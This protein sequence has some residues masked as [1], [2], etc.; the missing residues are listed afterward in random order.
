MLRT[1]R[2]RLIFSHVLPLLVVVPLI[3]LAL[4]Y[5]LEARIVLPMLSNELA[6]Q[7]GLVVEM[8]GDQP[9]VWTDASQAQAFVAR[10]SP[11]LT[12]RLMVL[13]RSGRLLASS[14]PNDSGRLGTPLDHPGM[15]QALSGQLFSQQTRSQGMQAEV[16]DVLAPAPG[17]DQ[18]VEGVVRLS[19]PLTTVYARFRLLRYLVGGV[20]I[21][22]LILGA[23]A[24][25]AL[26]VD[27]GRPIEQ[28]TQ[29]V[30]QLATGQAPASLSEQGPE[31]IRSLVHSFNT[32]AERLHMLEESRRRLLA[33]LVH[34]I[35]RP[36]GALL[37]AVQ[38]LAEGVDQDP[39]VRGELH[40]GMEAQIHHLQRLVSDLAQLH[41]REAGTPELNLR[42]VALDEWL[43]AMLRPWREAATQKRLEWRSSISPGLPVI[44]ADP[45]RLAQAVGNLVSNAIKYTPSQ[46]SVT[47]S[48]DT[49]A[50]QVWIRVSDTGPGIPAGEQEHVFTPFY[51][52]VSSGRFPQ[53]MGLGLSIAHDLVAAHG[54]R[55]T[56]EST[57]GS[58]SHF[59][60][61]LPLPT[62]GSQSPP[63]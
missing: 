5:L 30:R 2:R 20:L 63:Q 39:A 33:N 56:L 55:L 26:A 16:A 61:W 19:Y 24:G 47:V 27:L 14:D 60:I 51:R 29:A 22:G 49:E 13:D 42:P 54:G 23:I 21:A 15:G 6:H 34:E 12:A 25:A 4:I 41:N 7:A 43:P 1:L 8:A 59:T 36:L 35:G 46:G 11:R 52:G 9:G 58:G 53:G 40:A 57:P 3:G 48:A 45:D 31:E 17:Q 18:Q 28:T 32:L 38:A 62:P 50:G 44:A 10:V 37:A